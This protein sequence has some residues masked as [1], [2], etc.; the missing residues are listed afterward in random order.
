MALRGI[1]RTIEGNRLGF[2]CPG[3]QRMHQVV[4]G[5]GI[6]GWTFNGNYDL[7]TFFPSIQVEGVVP[8][9]DQQWSDY[10]QGKGLPKPVKFLCHSLVRDGRIEFLADCTHSLRGST[11][12]LAA[13]P[14]HEPDAV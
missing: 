5:D 4:V 6:R 2:W 3:C 8:L 11:V 9:T 14:S 13:P 1:L 7:P 10:Q 12:A